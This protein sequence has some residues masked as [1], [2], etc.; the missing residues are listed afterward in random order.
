[1][2]TPHRSSGGVG[3]VSVSS[4]F[5]LTDSLHCLHISVSP[6]EIVLADAGVT[7]SEM[8]YLGITCDPY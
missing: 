2:T 1:V 8:E 4:E 5:N 6:T 3:T 7:L